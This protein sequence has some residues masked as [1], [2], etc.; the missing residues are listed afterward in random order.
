MWKLL[1][2][3]TI[4]VYLYYMLFSNGCKIHALHYVEFHENTCTF[5]SYIHSWRATFVLKHYQKTCFLF[6]ILNVTFRCSSI[7]CWF[8]AVC[9]AALLCTTPCGGCGFTHIHIWKRTHPAL[10]DHMSRHM[11]MHDRL[12]KRVFRWEKCI[13]PWHPWIHSSFC[14]C[15]GMW[16]ERPIMADDCAIIWP[17]WWHNMRLH[18][19]CTPRSCQATL[20]FVVNNILS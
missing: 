6:S 17:S 10:L 16:S 18:A 7:T 11:N 15:L 2:I 1:E 19:L 20:V 3:I 14:I 9:R 8:W 12:P 13:I 4:N 5:G